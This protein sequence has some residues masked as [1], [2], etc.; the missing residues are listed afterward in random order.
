MRLIGR[1]EP[2]GGTRKTRRLLL[3][4]PDERG[5]IAPAALGR[6]MALKKIFA[7]S[8]VRDVKFWESGLV[9]TWLASMF[10][11]ALLAAQGR[12]SQLQTGNSIS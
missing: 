5:I 6:N 3:R 7:N 12:E 4:L 11:D 8:A 2:A 9:R 1:L 10:P